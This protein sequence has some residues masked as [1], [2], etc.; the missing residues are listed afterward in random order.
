MNGVIELPLRASEQILNIRYDGATTRT[1]E[2]KKKQN[3]GEK[4]LYRIHLRG[5][6]FVLNGDRPLRETKTLLLFFFC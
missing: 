1:E 2:N 3:N 5:R 4:K 6:T